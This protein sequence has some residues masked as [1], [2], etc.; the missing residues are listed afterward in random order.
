MSTIHKVSLSG[1][2]FRK[3]VKGEVLKIMMGPVGEQ[4]VIEL[5]CIDIGFGVMKD[6]VIEAER[7]SKNPD[8]T[9]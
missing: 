3:L 8:R 4:E 9:A 5:S 7:D 2:Q 1:E 6:S